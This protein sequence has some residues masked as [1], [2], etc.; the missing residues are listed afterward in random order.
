VSEFKYLGYVLK[1]NGGDDGKTRKL[2]KK[3][4]IVMKKVWGLG[5]R[6]FKDDFRGRMML[7]RYLIM[8]IIMYEAEIWG[9][10]EM[11]KLEVLQKKYVKCLLA[12]TSVRRTIYNIVYK[13]Y[14]FLTLYIVYKESGIDKIKIT[15]G[16]RAVKFEQKALK[17]DNK[18]LLIECIKVRERQ[19][20]REGWMGKREDFYKQNGFSSGGIKDLREREM[21]RP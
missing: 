7:F 15:T 14:L 19:R 3:S 12:S 8:A 1:K 13:V 18:R 2:K 6:I 11:V 4:N 21:Q 17:G 16:C 5:E 9:W 20:G 10:R